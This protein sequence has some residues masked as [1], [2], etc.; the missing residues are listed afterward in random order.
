MNL[1]LRRWLDAVGRPRAWPAGHRSGLRWILATKHLAGSAARDPPRRVDRCGRSWRRCARPVLDGV[2]DPRDPRPGPRPLRAQRSRRRPWLSC[3]SAWRACARPSPPGPAG[4]SRPWPRRSAAS[5]SG[6]DGAG[7]PRLRAG[8]AR[9]AASGSPPTSPPRPSSRAPAPFP[10][11]AVHRGRRPDA[12]V[13]ALAPGPSPIPGDL[14]ASAFYLLARWDELRVADRDRVRPAAAGRQRLRAHRRA[15]TWRTRR[16]RATSPP[17]GA[18]ARAS[19]RPRAWGV[20]ADPRHR[21]HAAAHAQGA[22]RPSPAAA[23]RAGWP[24]RSRGPGPMGQRA[25]PARRP[26]WRARRALDGLPDRAQR[27]PPRRHAA[28]RLRA[29][30]PARW[31]PPCGPPGGEVGLHGV[32]RLVGGRRRAGGR[33]RRACAPR[34]GPVAGV[35]FHYLRFRYHETVRVA[36]GAPARRYDSSLA[37]SEAPG[38]RRRHRPPLPARTWWA[39]SAR[40]A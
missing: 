40:P 19:R 15:S 8:P 17:C 26:T 6:R 4:C 30:A 36:R 29:R 18:G 39:R 9:A 7:R 3:A 34:P 32:V 31:P 11:D 1:P 10:G 33:A 2:L 16:S 22:G 27:P 28:A 24:P 20:A 12:A 25:R 14:V 35:R 13:P 38:L 37:F 21:P 5:R 23:G